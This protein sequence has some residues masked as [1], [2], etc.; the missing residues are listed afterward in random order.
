MDTITIVKYIIIMEYSMVLFTVIF[1]FAMYGIKVF[2][3]KRHSKKL[4]KLKAYLEIQI[5]QAKARPT[6]DDFIN[7]PANVLD[8]SIFLDVINE[9]NIKYRHNMQ[10]AKLR[11]AFLYYIA[12]PIAR[13]KALSFL[14][15]NK[16]LAAQIFSLFPLKRDEKILLN[17]V[18]NDNQVIQMYAFKALISIFS[19]VAIRRI[20]DIFSNE[21]M[22]NQSIILS[23]FLGSSMVIAK[24]VLNELE[25]TQDPTRRAICYKILFRCNIDKMK[26]FPSKKDIFSENIFLRLAV[27]KFLRKC[28]KKQAVPILLNF[29][30]D[31]EWQVKVRALHSIESLKDESLAV[32]VGKCL[33]DKEWWVRYNAAKVLTKLGKRGFYILE[34]QNKSKDLYAYEV[35]QHV[36]QEDNN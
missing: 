20:I 12:L 11:T 3:T 19:I 27:T 24:L 29:L 15:A 16:L 36:L 10:W 9:F 31:P 23:F 13:K 22:L 1:C 5:S 14:I 28:D 17:L 34:N 7:L 25:Q 18:Q 32:E 35:A 26:I 4:E 30:K 2:E 6:K 8:L 21:R 33:N